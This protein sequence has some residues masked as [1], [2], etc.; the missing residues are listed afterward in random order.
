MTQGSFLR[1]ILNVVV[2]DCSSRYAQF[3]VYVSFMIIF[4][5]SEAY[6][7]SLFCLI[8]FS[9]FRSSRANGEGGVDVTGTL[10]PLRAVMIII[11]IV[12]TVT[13][14]IHCHLLSL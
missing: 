3:S 1:K 13:V 6:T 14:I 2:N 5:I 12:I 4:S 11:V 8:H 7:R 10:M 9:Y